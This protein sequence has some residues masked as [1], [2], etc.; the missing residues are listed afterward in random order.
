MSRYIVGF[1][2]TNEKDYKIIRNLAEEGKE[3]RP[4]TKKRLPKYLQKKDLLLI[5]KSLESVLGF[6]QELDTLQEFNYAMYKTK[7]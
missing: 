7:K 6:M 4:E 3:I 5:F 1:C 2:L